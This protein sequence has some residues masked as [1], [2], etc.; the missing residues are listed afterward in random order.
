MGNFYVQ[1]KADMSDPAN[2]RVCLSYNTQAGYAA[3]LIDWDDVPKLVDA[4][5]SIEMTY[6]IIRGTKPKD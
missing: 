4:V 2:Q 1:D 5:G 6:G 3:L